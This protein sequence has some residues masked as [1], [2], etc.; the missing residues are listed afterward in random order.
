MVARQTFSDAA[1]TLPQRVLRNEISRVLREVE[2]GERFSV[3]VNGRIVAELGPPRAQQR[4]VEW[5]EAHAAIA[6]I[7][8]RHADDT[9][10]WSD[11]GGREH[12]VLEDPWQKAENRSS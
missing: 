1:V 8:A 11:I 4:G 7:R 3:T 5:R 10:F 2:A 6:R 9:S 12:E